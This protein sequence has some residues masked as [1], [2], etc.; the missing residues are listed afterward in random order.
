MLLLQL[1]NLPQTHG[2]EWYSKDLNPGPELHL[3]CDPALGHVLASRLHTQTL[4]FSASPTGP[5]PRAFTLEHPPPGRL[6][7][8]SPVHLSLTISMAFFASA[9]LRPSTALHLPLPRAVTRGPVSWWS[10]EMA[11]GCRSQHHLFLTRCA[12]AGAALIFAAAVRITQA[13]T[14]KA[15]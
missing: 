7:L 14:C 13:G 9:L 12:L 5:Q 4:P 2:F 10:P 15:N 3:H 11:S 6:F 8:H 1:S